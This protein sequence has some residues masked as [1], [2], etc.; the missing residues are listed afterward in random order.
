MVFG[1]GSFA[2]A[3]AFTS[4]FKAASSG[5]VGASSSGGAGVENTS[6]VNKVRESARLCRGPI[7]RFVRFVRAPQSSLICRRWHACP[8]PPQVPFASG[9]GSAAGSS[10]HAGERGS[11]DEGGSGDEGGPG[12]VYGE[13]EITAGP[14][15]RPPVV[16]ADT[17]PVTNGEEHE[18]VVVRV[19]AYSA[20]VC[21]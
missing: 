1:A 16:F 20:T 8:P 18:L 6:G 2:S 17:E 3:A 5:L 21:V 10:A 11:E 13:V 14:P 12:D 7:Q 15:D 4:S 19:Q 9:V